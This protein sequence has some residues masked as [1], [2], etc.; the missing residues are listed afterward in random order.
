MQSSDTYS[1]NVR[2]GQQ[3]KQPAKTR[4]MDDKLK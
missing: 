2:L 1:R 3:S 4:Q